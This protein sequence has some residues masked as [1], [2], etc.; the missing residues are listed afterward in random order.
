MA[1]Y[2]ISAQV[3]GESVVYAMNAV[4]APSR[5]SAGSLS[6]HK[7]EDGNMA[8]DN[9]RSEPDVITLVGKIS[10]VFVG[11]NISEAD[12][13]TTKEFIEGLDRIKSEAIPFT[14][15]YASDLTPKYPCFFKSVDISQGS[16]GTGF[17]GSDKSGNSIN[18]YNV[19]LTIEV[20][21]IG[22]GATFTT[23]PATAF[24]DQAQ[25]KKETSSATKIDNEQVDQALAEGL[26]QVLSGEQ[27]LA[28]SI[29]G[30]EG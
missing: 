22:K 12:R 2:Y 3:D 28:E 13:K 30:Q 18:S 27:T 24:V 1:T 8:S 29:T 15:H 11:N 19:S 26:F 6:R 21:R 25:P 23:A 9:Y 10:D 17:S 14:T 5:T 20:A 4:V 16:G 7:L